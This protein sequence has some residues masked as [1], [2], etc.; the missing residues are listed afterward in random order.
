MSDQSRNHNSEAR[1]DFKLRFMDF[2]NG[3][4]MLPLSTSNCL[5]GHG[6][7]EFLPV[8]SQKSGPFSMIPA[9]SVSKVT[10]VHLSVL[11]DPERSMSENQNVV[12]GYELKNCVASG[13]FNSDLGSVRSKERRLPLP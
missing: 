6:Y 4:H 10:A 12:G 3:S 1:Q 9:G 8:K 13:R 7:T 5:S 2:L 11:P